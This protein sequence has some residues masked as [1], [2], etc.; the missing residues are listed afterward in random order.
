MGRR[1]SIFIDI[2][3][4]YSI[5]DLAWF[6]KNKHIFFYPGS[7]V[8]LLEF[9]QPAPALG[10]MLGGTRTE[11]TYM[12][13]NVPMA[14]GD[15]IY[16]V[17]F[18]VMPDSIFEVA[19]GLEFVDA[20]AVSVSTKGYNNPS[21]GPRLLIPTPRSYCRPQVQ[22]NWEARW[23]YYN[24]RVPGKFEVSHERYNTVTVDPRSLSA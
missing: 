18:L 21:S 12:L 7:P 16:P 17:N 1:F 14:L 24:N 8:Q 23:A 3:C 11:A 10:V 6:L 22:R 20:Y 5:M 13:R 4:C 2:G 19:L 9:Q 15:G